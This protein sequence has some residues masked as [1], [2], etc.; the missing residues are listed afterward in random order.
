MSGRCASFP[1]V[2]SLRPCMS[3]RQ[4]Q[5]PCR[6]G[7]AIPM[8]DAG[9][10]ATPA[11]AGSVSP[12]R[13]RLLPQAV[14]PAEAGGTAQIH[15]GTSDRLNERRLS[16]VPGADLPSLNCGN[17]GDKAAAQRFSRYSSPSVFRRQKGR[18][19]PRTAPSGSTPKEESSAAGQVAQPGARG[20]L[21]PQR[22]CGARG[23]ES[24]ES[25]SISLALLP[26]KK[27]AATAAP[28]PSRD[29]RALRFIPA[30]R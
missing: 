10:L 5:R 22:D 27:E 3:N 12:A 11:T 17:Q 28:S 18:T 29:C 2:S 15:S 14:L 24:R 1:H 6:S 26:D 16:E 23:S 9:F 30:A 13:E 4:Q 8:G 19:R 7:H 20:C 25:P 21:V